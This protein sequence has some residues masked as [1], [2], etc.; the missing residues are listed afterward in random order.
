VVTPHI[1]QPLNGRP[2]LPTEKIIQPTSTEFFLE[3]KLEGAPKQP[4]EKND[5][6]TEKG[7]AQ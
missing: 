2:S 5:A 4:T 7:E 1:V 6:P 3:G